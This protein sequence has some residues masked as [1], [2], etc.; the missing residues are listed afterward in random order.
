[1]AYIYKGKPKT[2]PEVTEPEVRRYRGMGRNPRH[3]NG[4]GTH[5]GYATHKRHNSPVCLPCKAARNN[6]RNELDKAKR[7]MKKA[8]A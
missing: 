7:E 1:M 6:Y 2:V 4:C 5:A 3:G 8:A